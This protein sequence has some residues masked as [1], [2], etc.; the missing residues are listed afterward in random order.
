MCEYGPRHPAYA[1]A[2]TFPPSRIEEKILAGATSARASFAPL[3][4]KKLEIKVQRVA[5]LGN[6]ETCRV[7]AIKPDLAVKWRRV[8]N[9]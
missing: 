1:T 3:L 2:H 4:F 8:H 7:R 9:P 6:K 5:C